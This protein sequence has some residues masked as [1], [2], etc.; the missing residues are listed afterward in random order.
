MPLRAVFPNT[1]VCLNYYFTNS[2]WQSIIFAPL[3]TSLFIN[4][5]GV[6]GSTKLV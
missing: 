2:Y 1:N 5:W 6:K 3:M 4:D